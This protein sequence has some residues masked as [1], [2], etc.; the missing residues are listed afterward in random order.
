MKK[1]RIRKQLL[2]DPGIVEILERESEEQSES[3]STIANRLIAPADRNP[4]QFLDATADWLWEMD[5]HFRYTHLSTAYD[6]TVAMWTGIKAEEVI[7][8]T[9]EELLVLLNENHLTVQSTYL[10]VGTTFLHRRKA[11]SNFECEYQLCDGSGAI[12]AVRYLSVSGSPIFNGGQFMGF[13]G[14][15]RDISS[16]KLQNSLLLAF[17]DAEKISDWTWRTDSEG[18]FSEIS[19]EFEAATG[20]SA[21]EIIGL[22]RS[23]WVRCSNSDYFDLDLIER[24]VESREIFVDARYVSMHPNGLLK[25]FSISGFPEFDPDGRF[26]G[27]KGIGTDVTDMNAGVAELQ[28][29]I[30]WTWRTDATHKLIFISDSYEAISGHP[31][32]EIGITR[33]DIHRRDPDIFSGTSS[34]SYRYEGMDNYLASILAMEPFECLYL[35]MEGQRY[36]ISGKPW[37]NAQGVFEGYFG[38]TE[39]IQQ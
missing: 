33:W 30:A 25:E 26:I 27:Y 8:K 22:T 11:F 15:G 24:Q 37:W 1:N 9:R 10:D 20:A 29:D 31:P 19:Q 14:T 38:I 16:S 4:S 36:R 6:R 39:L 3:I 5:S 18:R 34:Y 17:S 12:L 28:T 35:V 2:L 32:F 21:R 13:R 7:G 23:Q